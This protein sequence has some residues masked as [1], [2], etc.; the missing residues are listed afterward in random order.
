MPEAVETSS[1]SLRLSGSG[2]SGHTIPLSTA[3]SILQTFQ[4]LIT[5]LGAS[6]E[7]K[8]TARGKLPDSLVQ[9][10]RLALSASPQP[11]SV[12]LSFSPAEA[13]DGALLKDSAAEDLIHRTFKELGDLLEMD[14]VTGEAQTET[15]DMQKEKFAERIYNLG[16]RV[17]RAMTDFARDLATNNVDMGLSWSHTDH[18][19][20]YVGLTAERFTRVQEALEDIRVRSSVTGIRAVIQ[21]I[22]TVPTDQLELR[23]EEQ[24]KS[25]KDLED[26]P[27][28]VTVSVP[29]DV[30]DITAF[31]VRD[32]VAFIA[33]VD[34]TAFPGRTPKLSVEAYE[35]LEPGSFQCLTPEF[36]DKVEEHL[37][38]QQA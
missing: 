36:L 32:E 28:V 33:I 16:P 34:S 24:I 1:G 35:I 26:L 31:R 13:E 17:A 12:V 22:S 14:E 21:K 27:T 4:T 3:G 11:G 8:K 25:N 6:L 20:T 30:A 10:T 7:G 38:N 9:S 23:L 2:V 37:E 18:R 29:D 19:P 15:S 5:S